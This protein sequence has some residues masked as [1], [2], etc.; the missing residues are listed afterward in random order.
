MSHYRF[1]PLSGECVIISK[2]RKRR[3]SDFAYTSNVGDSIVSP[4]TYGNESKTPP[5]IYAIRDNGSAVNKPGWKV[6][7]VPNKFNAL[8]IEKEPKKIRFGLYDTMDGFGAHEVVIDTPRFPSDIYDYSIEETELLLAAIFARVRDLSRDSRL[9]YILP[10][11]N[12]GPFSGATIAHPHTQIMAMPFM[13]LSVETELV[14]CKRYH[15]EHFRSLLEDMVQEEIS[16]NSRVVIRSEHFLVFCPFAS[17]YPFSIFIMPISQ[18]TDILS[19][20]INVKKELSCVLNDAIFRLGQAIEGLSFNMI[21]K[22]K[23]PVRE[24]EKELNIYHLMDEYHGW[25]IELQPR[26]AFDG[27]LEVGSGIM[28]NSVLP[29]EAAEFFINVKR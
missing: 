13:P 10:F 4:F 14:K 8:D 19:L 27:G 20:D 3:P 18:K 23:P 9:K 1:C 2:K 6:R 16:A 12:S 15:S 22:L 11:K 7:V 17:M 29:V 5:E 24:D 25:R 26:L 28:I 21:F